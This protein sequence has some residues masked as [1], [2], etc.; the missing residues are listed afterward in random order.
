M[1]G[2]YLKSTYLSISSTLRYQIELAFALLCDLPAVF[3]VETF[4][5]FF[6]EKEKLKLFINVSRMNQL[7][8][9]NEIVVEHPSSTLKNL[10]KC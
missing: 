4:F 7:K 9:Q 8:L 10:E 6:F 2:T 5:F 1:V 3:S